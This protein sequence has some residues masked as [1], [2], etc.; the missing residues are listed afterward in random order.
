MCIHLISNM[1]SGTGVLEYADQVY[2]N[3]AQSPVPRHS[4]DRKQV[5]DS[6]SDSIE[7]I[8]FLVVDEAHHIY[9]PSVAV[10]D[11]FRLAVTNLVEKSARVVYCTDLSQAVD[12]AQL[13][14]PAATQ[15]LQLKEVACSE[16][17][18]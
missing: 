17:W 13:L 18:W 7:S 15:T 10:S 1:A 5:A 9:A 8:A 4:K 3:T 14:F 6:S 11:T 2:S 16:G 12:E